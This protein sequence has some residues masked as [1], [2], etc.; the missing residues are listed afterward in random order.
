MFSARR[1]KTVAQ[2]AGSVRGW[3]DGKLN[4]H[5]RAPTLGEA[6]YACSASCSRRIPKSRSPTTPFQVFLFASGDSLA[7]QWVA[8]ADGMLEVET[9]WQ[10]RLRVP[11][12]D[13]SIIRFR[14]GK[15]TFLPD[16]DPISVEEVGF[17]GRVIPWRRDQ[18]FDD[19]PAH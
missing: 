12:A 10:A 15:L 7:G 2:V 5:F 4:P 9:A 18:G 13:L 11:A 3:S 17:F 6:K 19:G 14:N 8:L 1:D 16:L